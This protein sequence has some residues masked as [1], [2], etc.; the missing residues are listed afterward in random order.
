MENMDK[1]GCA[2]CDMHSMHDHACC[3]GMC[4][5]HGCH[6]GHYHLLKMVLKIA[7]VIIIFSCGFRLGEMTGFIKAN[8]GYGEYNKSGYGM[9]RGGS[10]FN[11]AP[12]VDN[13]APLQ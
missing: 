7:I 5:N 3:G 10:Y 8:G 4:G 13:G 11:Y 6:G 1:K 9:M 12:A 2:E